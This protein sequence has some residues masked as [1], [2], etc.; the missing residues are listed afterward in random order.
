VRFAHQ[1]LVKV[2]ATVAMS[3]LLLALVVRGVSAIRAGNAPW[4]NFFGAPVTPGLMAVMGA[5]IVL[6][7]L[8]KLW[9]PVGSL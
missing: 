1:A 9:A 3:V 4:T 2:A 6:V 8:L 5:L 7:L